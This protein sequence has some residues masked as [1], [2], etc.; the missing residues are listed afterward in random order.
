M[1]TSISCHC[2]PIE[3]GKVAIEIKY[4]PDE[5]LPEENSE[6]VIKVSVPSRSLIILVNDALNLFHLQ[7][8]CMKMCPKS[9]E[10]RLF[11]RVSNIINQC[12][13]ELASHFQ[14]LSGQ[15]F[16]QS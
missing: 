7:S 3:N 16:S 10:I 14:F 1:V 8:K 6:G 11:S 12:Y 13:E 2:C 15:W 4:D 9:T 5:I